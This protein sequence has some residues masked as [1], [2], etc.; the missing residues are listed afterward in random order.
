[1]SI[2]VV[3][4]NTYTAKKKRIKR[5]PKL[6]TNAVAGATKRDILEIKKIFH[7]GIKGRSLR[8]DALATVT[9]DS[10]K[11]KGMKAPKTPLYGKGDGAKDRSYMNMLNIRKLKNGWTLR[12]STRKHWSGKITLK[13]L[14]MIHEHGAKIMR[15]EK[16]IQIPPRPALLMSFRKWANI[17][18]R[19]KKETANEVK[20]ALVALIQNADVSKM[21]ILEN[22]AKKKVI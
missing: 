16:M 15:G 12:P 18:K 17:K 5:L 9:I 21:K 20:A 3:F 14:F 13:H 11:D 22:F 2:K 8:L 10:K 19:S 6:I 7:D 1:M 4:S